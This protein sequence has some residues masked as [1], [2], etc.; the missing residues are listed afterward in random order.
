[1]FNVIQYKESKWDF[2][3]KTKWWTSN[4]DGRE[5]INAKVK[6]PHTEPGDAGYQPLHDKSKEDFKK[7]MYPGNESIII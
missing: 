7:E 1:M 3:K 2:R 4:I 5:E 6:L